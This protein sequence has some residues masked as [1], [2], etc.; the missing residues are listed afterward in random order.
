MKI[1]FQATSEIVEF[2]PVSLNFDFKRIKP[3]IVSA[4][5]SFVTYVIDPETYQLLLGEYETPANETYAEALKLLQELLIHFAYFKQLPFLTVVL[6]DN[7][8]TT[9]SKD[10]GKGTVRK[11]QLDALQDA[12]LDNAHE[13]V[14]SLLRFFEENEG[15]FESWRSSKFYT[16]RNDLFVNA[17]ELFSEHYNIKNSYRMFLALR[18]HLKAAERAFSKKLATYSELKERFQDGTLTIEDE[19]LLSYIHPVLV[20]RALAIGIVSLSVEMVPGGI[21]TQAF[22]QEGKEPSSAKLDRILILQ[23]EFA[24]QAETFEN[25]FEQFQKQQTGEERSFYRV[26]NSAD[27]K[28]FHV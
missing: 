20:Y 10:Q 22:R 15:S 12:E 13:A 8:H 23:Q 11:W 14:N 9:E 6:S 3:A 17:P 16:K 26:P 28:I 7:V 18:T 21:L 1:P 27:K 5:R 25:D 24:Q 19:A 4:A 2:I